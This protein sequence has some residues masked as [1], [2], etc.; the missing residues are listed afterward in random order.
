MPLSLPSLERLT[1]YM[2]W[3]AT[4]DCRRNSISMLAQKHFHHEELHGVDAV[5]CLRMLEERKG[6]RWEDTPPFFRFGTFVKKEENWKAAFNPKTQQQVSA[7]RTR[8]AA[9]SF[10]LDEAAAP[11]WLLARFWPATNADTTA[12]L[13]P[14]DDAGEACLMGMTD[15]D[16]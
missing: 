7:R 11:E 2:R 4:L 3:R 6:V 1:A 5:T 10:E 13:Q 9:R 15:A 12:I 14:S 8:S 16:A